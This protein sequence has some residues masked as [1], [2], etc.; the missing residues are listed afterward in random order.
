MGDE[1]DSLN[2][3]INCHVNGLTYIIATF[4]IF[5]IREIHMLPQII[6]PVISRCYQKIFFS[7]GKMLLHL[8]I[9][10]LYKSSFAHRFYNPGSSQN[11]DSSHNSQTW[12]KGFLCN[13]QHLQEREM[14][15][16]SPPS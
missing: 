11:G 16:F 3:H 10:T 5:F 2:S 12:I 9:D 15:I 7:L 14:M 1:K 4:D 6:C 8:Y 13:F